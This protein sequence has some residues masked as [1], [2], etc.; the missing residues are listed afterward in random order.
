MKASTLALGLLAACA[1]L[2]GC[3][4]GHTNP[5]D[6]VIQTKFPGQVTAGGLTS[7]QIMAKSAKPETNAAYAGGTPGIAGGAGGTTGGAALGGTVTET[8]QGP[9]QGA[10]TPASAAQGGNKPQGDNGAPPANAPA[11][12][13]TPVGA[14]TATNQDSKPAAAPGTLTGDK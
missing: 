13:V 4:R 12:G 1:A 11:A 7:G 14:G 9:S 8:G 5:K 3:D 10:T 6:G 2:A